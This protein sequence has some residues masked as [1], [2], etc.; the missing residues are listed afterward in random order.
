MELKK[1]IKQFTKEENEILL[2]NY[3]GKTYKQLLELFPDKTLRQLQSRCNYLKLDITKET[4][5]WS[6]SEIELL[7][8]LYPIKSN[9]DLA[10]YFKKHTKK[11]I[12]SKAKDLNLEKSYNWR[13]NN[14]FF[15]NI[16]V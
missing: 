15:I 8:I 11:S 2:N 6:E 4:H 10:N 3:K 5:S 14:L 13:I 12:Y 9:E 7:K 1:K 16:F